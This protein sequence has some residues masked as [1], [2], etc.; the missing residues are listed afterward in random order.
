VKRLITAVA[1]LATVTAMASA[2]IPPQTR[3]KFHQLYPKIPA[4]GFDSSPVEG[5]VEVRTQDTVFYFAPDSGLLLFGEFFDPAAVSL[6][7]RRRDALASRAPH[8]GSALEGSAKSL[9]APG[10]LRLR[11]GQIEVTAY[12]DVHCGYCAQAVDWLVQENGLPGAA[13]N[14]VFV[15]RNEQDLALAEH[16]LCAPTRLRAAAL[17]QVFSRRPGIEPR[18][19]EKGRAEALAHEQIAARNGVSATPVFSVKGQTVLGFNRERLES[20]V[21][22][23]GAQPKG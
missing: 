8:D 23:T 15:S 1:L 14:V 20:L 4:S 11:D 10:G 21:V 2:E 9:A 17:Q 16:V 13:L 22:R 6:T 7:G 18:R 12:L 3:E 5:L 19:C